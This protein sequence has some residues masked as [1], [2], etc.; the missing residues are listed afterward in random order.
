MN[1]N[2]HKNEVDEILRVPPAKLTAYS[3]ILVSIGLLVFFAVGLLVSIPEE[4]VGNV[5]V[6]NNNA[7][8]NICAR[9]GGR[10]AKLFVSNKVTVKKGEVLAMINN[11]MG[12]REYQDIENALIRI[13]T[14]LST[15]DSIALSVFEMPALNSLGGMQSSYQETRKRLKQFS[16]HILSNEHAR[17]C[18]A[19]KEE[20]HI[21]QAIDDGLAAR[22]K[23]LEQSVNTKT[24]N[25]RR[26]QQLHASKLISDAELETVETDIM[27]EEM[28]LEIMKSD[29]LDNKLKMLNCNKQLI[30]LQWKFNKERDALFLGVNGICEQVHQQ[31][32]LWEEKYLLRAPVSGLVQLTDFWEEQQHVNTGE[33]VMTIL[34]DK[35]QLI[36]AKMQCPANQAAKVKP[37]NEVLIELQGHPAI[38]HGYIRGEVKSIS[39]VQL[40]GKYTVNIMLAG[41][42]NT[43]VGK[44]IKFNRYAEG[45]AKIITGKKVFLAHLAKKIFPHN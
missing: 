12:F 21:Y 26:M 2:Y 29:I 14:L 25:L 45:R 23:L 24:R 16:S 32:Q 41:G 30:D 11:P 37:G 1:H 10:I 36:S 33:V 27:Q 7:W 42:L 39:E 20:Q 3:T 22:F 43:T 15:G 13:D 35:E 31:L 4:S 5:R 28:K 40:E 44:T 19:I 6:F 38:T 17:Q 34:P 8:V 9:K 18:G